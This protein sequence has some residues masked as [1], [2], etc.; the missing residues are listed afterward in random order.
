[1]MKFMFAVPQGSNRFSALSSKWYGK[2]GAENLRHVL[3]VLFL[4][5]A[6]GLCFTTVFYSEFH[7]L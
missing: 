3:D 6:A 5:V 7:S 4:S 1:M 2:T